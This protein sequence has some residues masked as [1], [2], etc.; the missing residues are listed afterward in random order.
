A[1]CASRLAELLCGGS[2]SD[3]PNYPIRGMP[4]P[5]VLRYATA[6]DA[7]ELAEFA[8]KAFSD[9]YRDLDDPKD[10]ADY[11]AEHFNVPAVTSVLRD[12]ACTTLLA[13]LAGKIVGYAVLKSAEPPACV[14]GPKPIELARLYVG[15]DFLG[16][17]LGSQVMRAVHAEARRQSSKTLWLGVYDRNVR[18]VAFYERSG[19]RKVGGKEFLFGGRIY[20]D[21]IY[22][23]RVQSDA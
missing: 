3:L 5:I 19:F 2:S 9:T 14:A 22:S 16:Q 4:A 17:G 7:P 10:I 21:P 13:T 23:S 1:N 8:A 6:Q 12:E 15:D 11:V 18:A 20:V